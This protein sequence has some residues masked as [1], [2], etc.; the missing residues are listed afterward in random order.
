MTWRNGGRIGPCIAAMV[1]LAIAGT[2]GTPR[3]AFSATGEI[4]GLI[5][6]PDGKPLS[7]AAVHARMPTYVGQRER[8]F[9]KGRDATT[10]ARGEY[11]IEGLA[12]GKYYVWATQNEPSAVPTFFPAAMDWQASSRVEVGSETPRGGID[13]RLFRTRPVRVSGVVTDTAGVA[14]ADVAVMLSSP[15]NDPAQRGAQGSSAMTDASGRFEFVDVRA[16]HYIVEAFTKERLERISATGSTPGTQ[17]PGETAYL[18]VEVV[19]TDVKDLA[20]TMTRATLVTA[21]VTI[22]GEEAT[23]PLLRF[24]KLAIVDVQAA[25][26]FANLRTSTPQ[27]G[28]TLPRSNLRVAQGLRRFDLELPPTVALQ[29]V[30]LGARDVADDGFEVGSAAILD[31][32]IQLSSKISTITGQVVDTQG[33]PVAG[34]S[35]VV[36]STEPTHWTS[37][38]LRRVQSTTVDPRGGF[39]LK[40]MPSGTYFAIAVSDLPDGEWAEP[41]MLEKWRTQATQFSISN[42]GSHTLRLPIHAS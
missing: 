12:P 24:V 34:G 22:D 38:S 10:D 42:G 16:G 4:S 32:E 37:S 17:D 9:L 13:V 26:V 6:D 20:V 3:W 41:E 33:Q 27:A 31:V 40:G 11:R 21:R 30:L 25:T 23:M 15:A 35:V 1:L 7:G 29:A 14:R 28:I 2:D 36:F 8:R 39:T 5:L 19:D 18:P